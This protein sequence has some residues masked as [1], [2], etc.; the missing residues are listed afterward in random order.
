MDSRLAFSLARARRC[1]FSDGGVLEFRAADFDYR[2]FRIRLTQYGSPLRARLRSRE[3]MGSERAQEPCRRSLG[4][5]SA[6]KVTLLGYPEDEMTVIPYLELQRTESAT[7]TRVTSRMSRGTSI[8]L[9][10]NDF[11][12]TILA[13]ILRGSLARA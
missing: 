10:A 3:S 5:M 2:N 1:V 6:S 4:S 9:T 13:P 7:N 12:M 11:K 8:G